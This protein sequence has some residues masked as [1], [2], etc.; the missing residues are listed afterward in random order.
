M[1]GRVVSTV[2]RVVAMACLAAGAWGFAGAGG[3]STRSNDPYGFSRGYQVSH[4]LE[5]AVALQ[6]LDAEAR[7]KELQAMAADP[8]RASEV[9]PLCQM[10]LEDNGKGKFRRPRIGGPQFVDGGTMADWPQEPITLFQDIPILVATTYMLAGSPERPADYVTFCLANGK[11]RET[12]YAVLEAGEIRKRID[13]FLAAHPKIAGA[14]ADWVRKQ[15]GTG[16]T[17]Q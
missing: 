12:K 4:Y 3:P 2:G 10:L 5:Q 15:G 7:V 8:A 11:W 16:E 14:S 9:F 1:N 13:A 17:V 6:K